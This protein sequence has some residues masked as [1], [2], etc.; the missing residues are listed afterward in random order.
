[1][2]NFIR[3]VAILAL[4]AIAGQMNAAVFY[5]DGAISSILAC[6]LQGNDH[7]NIIDKINS[8]LRQAKYQADSFVITEDVL[9]NHSNQTGDCSWFRAFEKKRKR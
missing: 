6:D 2:K 8:A 1:M 3:I 7:Q 9:T 5:E 4:G